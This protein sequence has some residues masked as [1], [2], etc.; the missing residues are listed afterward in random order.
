M[1]NN[2]NKM[3]DFLWDGSNIGEIK[4]YI[5]NFTV[6]PGAVVLEFKNNIEAYITSTGNNTNICLIADE[7]KPIFKLEKI[8]RHL[9]TWNENPAILHRKKGE[10]CTMKYN[11]G[12]VSR[13]D[14][15][16]TYLYRWCL[17]L[18]QNYESAILVRRYKSGICHVTSLVE[19]M[20]DYTKHSPHGSEIPKTA[21]K[22]WFD[23]THDF[24]A[25]GRLLF[26][27]LSYNEIHSEIC[28][29]ID[30][31]DKKYKFWAQLICERVAI[32]IRI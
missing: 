20:Y 6:H 13:R 21:I 31:I 24:N 9:C 29:V 30:R 14:V 16:L 15:Q 1:M 28:S 22:A 27:G 19:K 8:G 18:T 3:I 2:R 26:K 23:E 10:E 25:V 4:N 7:L 32:F 5:I 17:G 11:I 12:I